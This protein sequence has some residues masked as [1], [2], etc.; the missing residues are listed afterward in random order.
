MYT[1][2]AVV[3]LVLVLLVFPVAQAG[4]LSIVIDDVGYLLKEDNAILNMPVAIAVAILPNAP[5][6]NL[7]AT[8]AHQQGREILIHLPMA[9]LSKQRLERDTLQPSMSNEEVQRI[10][11]NAV[12]NVPYAVG[13]NNHMGSAMTSSL[14][15]MQKVMQALSGYRLYFLDSMTIGNSQATSAAAGTEVKVLKRNVFLDDTADQEEIRRQFNR[16]IDLARRNGS[17]IAIGHPRPDTIKVLQRMLA[18]LPADIVLVAPS[19]LLDETPKPAVSSLPQQ[20][21]RKIPKSPLFTGAI[22]QCKVSLPK[23]AVTAYKVLSIIG[24]SMEQSS[25]V[26]LLKCHW[27]HWSGL[28]YPDLHPSSMKLQHKNACAGPKNEVQGG[29][30]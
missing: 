1:R 26:M 30:K 20:N 9:P 7:M 24:E 23:E 15:G 16:A 12:D 25:V 6:A 4:K 29:V 8:K 19:K 18:A 17:A 3:L 22:K 27:Q 10:L 21:R 2:L 5:H 14:S 11:R 28:A 13:L